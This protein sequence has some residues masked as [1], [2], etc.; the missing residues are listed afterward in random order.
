MIAPADD[1]T[2]DAHAVIAA[3]WAEHDAALSGNALL[4]QRDG[5]YGDMPA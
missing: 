1:T 3:L 2:A 5:E 4:A